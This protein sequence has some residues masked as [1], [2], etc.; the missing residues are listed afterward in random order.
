MLPNGEIA[1][2]GRVDEQVKIRGY[3][4]EPGEVAACLNRCP[5]VAACAVAVREEEGADGPVLV[6]YVVASPGARPT[7]SGLRDFLAR[8]LPDYMI[9][10]RY[11]ALAA[12][13]VTANGKLDRPASYA[14]PRRRQRWLPGIGRLDDGHAATLPLSTATNGVEAHLGDGYRRQ[15]A[16]LVASLLGQASVGMDENFFLIGGHSMLGAQLVARI[17]DRFGVKLT[18]RQLFTAPTVAALSAVV[19]RLALDAEKAHAP[20]GRGNA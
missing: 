7:V 4:V 18:L 2:L 9:P 20:P 14:A 8:R 11:V 17:R 1:F 16:S 19:A 12:L 13:P 3:R 6:A 5:G 15:I 10:A